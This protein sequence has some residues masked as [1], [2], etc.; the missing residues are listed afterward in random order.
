MAVRSAYV[1]PDGTEYIR[2]EL[3]THE[4]AAAA[5]TARRGIGPRKAQPREFYA[6]IDPA[7]LIKQPVSH[8]RRWTDEQWL[9]FHEHEAVQRDR[10]EP[11]VSAVEWVIRGA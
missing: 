9:A 5:V 6:G 8:R 3:P 4:V 1:A 11:E 10:D 2:V 7:R